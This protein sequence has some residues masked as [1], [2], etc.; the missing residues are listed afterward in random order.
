MVARGHLRH[1]VTDPE[2]RR[3]LTPGYR[4]GCKRPTFSNAYYPALTQ[5]NVDVITDGI[6]EV[7]EHS[8]VTSDGTEHEVDAI[9]F[10]TG[11]QL[12]A[13]PGLGRIRGVGGASL[14]DVWAGEG[15]TYLGTVVS[16]FP[17]MFVILGPNSALYTSQVVTI[18]A[19]VNYILSAVTTVE[20]H[21]LGAIDVRPEV[22]QD[23]VDKVDRRLA[24]SVW[25]SGGC[26][27][28]YLTDSG[29]NFTFWPGFAWQFQR[30][31]AQVNLADYRTSAPSKHRVD[32]PVRTP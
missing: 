23:F 2:L 8:V 12:S 10:G 13:H 19:Q 22:Q 16:G 18:E 14:N 28:Y 26:S 24:P 30:T 7:R 1:Q 11:F 20:N 21:G 31:T 32:E 9:V 4:F 3:K 15:K 29:R 27:S 5:P 25:N 17:N 6:T